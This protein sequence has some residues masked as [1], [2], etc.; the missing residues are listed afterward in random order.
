[1][2]RTQIRELLRLSPGQRLRSAA[3]D[4]RGLEH[5]LRSTKR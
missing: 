5:L 3:R 1:V 4:A 2:D